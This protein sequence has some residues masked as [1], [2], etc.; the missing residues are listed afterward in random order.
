MVSE[1]VGN[2]FPMRDSSNFMKEQ[3]PSEDAMTSNS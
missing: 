3:K 1:S 2:G